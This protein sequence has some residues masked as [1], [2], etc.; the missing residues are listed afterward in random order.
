MLKKKN[1]VCGMWATRQHLPKSVGSCWRKKKNKEQ[2]SSFLSQ[3]K[4]FHLRKKAFLVTMDKR[5]FFSQKFFCRFL[6][7]KK[8]KKKQVALLYK[9]KHKLPKTLIPV[10]AIANE[11]VF[12]LL[13]VDFCVV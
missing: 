3:N 12:L 10:N 5:F 6:S 4:S 13:T 9:T 2:A 8:R 7:L 11:C 1:Q